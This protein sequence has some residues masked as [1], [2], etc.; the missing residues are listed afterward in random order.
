MAYLCLYFPF[1]DDLP[2][3]LIFLSDLDFSVLFFSDFTFSC[4]PFSPLDLSQLL[5]SSVLLLSSLNFSCLNLTL[6]EGRMSSDFVLNISSLNLSA[7]V[8]SALIV[9]TSDPR[10]LALSNFLTSSVAL[11]LSSTMSGIGIQS[12]PESARWR[13]WTA[14][15]STVAFSC[16]GDNALQSNGEGGVSRFLGRMNFLVLTFIGAESVGLARA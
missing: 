11:G 3:S 13:G 2:E 14:K 7:L 9:S 4:L 15:K 12:V 5:P 10:L 8:F 16:S 1:D 6:S